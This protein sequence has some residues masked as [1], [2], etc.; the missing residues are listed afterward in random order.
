MPEVVGRTQISPI[1]FTFG[2]PPPLPT[3]PIVI[4]EEDADVDVEGNSSSNGSLVRGQENLEICGPEIVT[5]NVEE[6]DEKPVVSK[7]NIAFPHHAY[8]HPN[9]EFSQGGGDF[10][11][12]CN[13]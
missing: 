8:Y 10:R 13:P 6:E 12:V 1:Q 4:G 2:N 7:C 11:P 5:E 9:P 3:Q